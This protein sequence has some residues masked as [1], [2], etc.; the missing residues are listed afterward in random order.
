MQALLTKQHTQFIKHLKCLCSYHLMAYPEEMEYY[1]K[2]KN[3][4]IK[5]QQEGR[6]YTQ[7]HPNVKVLT[8]NFV[9]YD[10]EIEFD[11]NHHDLNSLARKMIK[12]LGC[13]QIDSKMIKYFEGHLCQI[14]LES[15]EKQ[16]VHQE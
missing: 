5:I 15:K 12:K 11:L 2:E 9:S 8:F 1:L 7:F 6:K 3:R 4:V 14:D 13:T 10:W 16:Q